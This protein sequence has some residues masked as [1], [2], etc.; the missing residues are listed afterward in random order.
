[1]LGQRS[2]DAGT[3]AGRPAPSCANATIAADKTVNP[4]SPAKVM[5]RHLVKA[6]RHGQ[7]LV[8]GSGFEYRDDPNYKGDDS[9]ELAISGLNVKVPG[10]STIRV[11][12]YI[13]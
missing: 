4:A 1:M 10:N 13:R 12:V 7:V 11:L 9:F 8:R 6:A 5:W 2:M 3:S